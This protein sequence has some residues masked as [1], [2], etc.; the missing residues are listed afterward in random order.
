MGAKEKGRRAEIAG[1]GIGGLTAATALAQRGWTVRV[2]EQAPTLRS[3]G[4]GIYLWENGIRVLTAIGAGAALDGA[5]WAY[6]RETRDERNRITNS[7][8]WN[9]ANP[10]RLVAVTRDRLHRALVAAA[11]AAG[12]TIVTRSEVVAATADGTLSLADGTRIAADLIV[13]AD[14]VNSRV[15]D[16]LGLLKRRKLLPDGAIRLIIPR[17]AGEAVADDGRK[18]IEWCADTRRIVY[19]PCSDEDLYLAL[20]AYD[21]DIEAKALP[22]RKDVWKRSFPFLSDLIDRIGDEGRW[23]RFETIRLKRWPAGRVAIIG[24]AAHA[25]P[26]NLGQGGACAMMIGLALAVHLEE[27]PDLATGLKRWEQTERGLI[28]HTQRMSHLYGVIANWSPVLRT[29]SLAMLGRSPWAM[30][31][32]LRAAAHRPTGA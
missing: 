32:R 22:V 21:T 30:A 29:A 5:H 28:E 11:V 6:A 26:P 3:Y 18:F 12:V 31:Q 2:H 9:T 24:D 20:V 13:A 19:T 23:D 1:A 4:A 25:Q 16:S 27:A 10:L 14:G 17:T 7:I 8:R 15:R